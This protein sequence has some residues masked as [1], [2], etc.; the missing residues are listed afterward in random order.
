MRVFY[1]VFLLA[2]GVGLALAFTKLTKDN[3]KDF[4]T[5]ESLPNTNETREVHVILV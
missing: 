2:H 5:I 1:L 3:F 4:I